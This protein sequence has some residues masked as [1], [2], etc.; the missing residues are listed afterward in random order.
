MSNTNQK[1]TTFL[2]FEGKAEEAMNFYT[3]LF[4]QSEIVSISR[5]DENG[6]G[7]EG[8][9]IHA[10]FT[11]NGQEFMCI[12]SYVNHNFTFTPAMSLYVTCE[13][14]EEIETVFHKL[15]QDGAILMPLGAY[16]FSKKFGWLNDKYGVSWQLTLAE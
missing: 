2:M 7:K 4:D 10:T 16:P 8:T 13:T 9:V 3:S 12:D 14:E 1:I 6:P 15:A 5:Y 11:L